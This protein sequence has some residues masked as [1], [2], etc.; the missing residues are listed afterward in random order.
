M[1]IG[2][3]L[4][5]LLYSCKTVRISEKGSFSATKYNISE[6][7]A[8]MIDYAQKD[9]DVWLGIANKILDSAQMTIIESDS[10]KVTRKYIKINDTVI[11]EYFNYTPNQI[12]RNA[13]FCIGNESRHTSY[14]EYLIKLAINTNS[15]IVAWNYRGFGYSTSKPT[16]EGQFADNQNMLNKLFVS[17]VN[18]TIMLGYSL[19][20]I[21]A[22]EMAANNTFDKLVLLA[23]VSDA[24]EL[25]KHYKRAYLSGLLV[26]ARPFIKLKADA[27]LL[28]ISNTENIKK[29]H[30]KLLIMHSKDDKT[31]PYKMGKIL[32]ENAGTEQKQFIKL[33]KGGHGAA[34]LPE[35]WEKVLDWIN[36]K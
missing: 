8:E 2:M 22:T 7:S 25:L 3:L 28:A 27:K 11:L 10:I 18:E 9:R 36:E 5:V 13:V 23:P 19:G 35:N 21:F 26:F 1:L 17:N 32:Y 33:K 15:E 12:Q 31:I 14:V 34:M 30:N 20:T 29:Y 16:F 24:P 4:L 6:D